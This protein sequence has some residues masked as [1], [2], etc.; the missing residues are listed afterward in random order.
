[1][2]APSFLADHGTKIPQEIKMEV[3]VNLIG[4]ELNTKIFVKY[5][6]DPKNDF[7]N[8]GTK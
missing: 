8:C 3:R 4:F 6:G 2:T 7:Y 1:V 5:L